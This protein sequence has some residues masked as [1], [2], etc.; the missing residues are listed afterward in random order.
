M[1]SKNKKRIVVTLPEDLVMKIDEHIAQGYK[2]SRTDLIE[3]CLKRFFDDESGEH[4][5]KDKIMGGSITAILS[6]LQL[7]VQTSESLEKV[8][9][10]I[11][12]LLE[13]VK[14]FYL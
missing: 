14:V 2:A 13:K 3:D 7:V 4:G 5:K 1:I 12:E 8:D 11:T 10:H 6:A 9:K